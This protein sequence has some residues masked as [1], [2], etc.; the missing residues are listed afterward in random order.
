MGSKMGY[1]RGQIRV[2]GVHI[3]MGSGTGPPGMAQRARS[4]DTGVSGMP[5]KT[6]DATRDSRPSLVWFHFVVC[7]TPNG[8]KWDILDLG[9][10]GLVQS[11]PEWSRIPGMHCKP[12]CRGV[13]RGP[14]RVLNGSYP[15]RA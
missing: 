15:G 1:F 4:A 9:M 14:K 12:P 7:G 13:L 10:V 11:G 3:S 6:S 5:S 2:P 8:P